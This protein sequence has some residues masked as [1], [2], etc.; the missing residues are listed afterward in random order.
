M[1]YRRDIVYV[2][3]RICYQSVEKAK[4]MGDSLVLI[5][6]KVESRSN[7]VNV[8]SGKITFI[9]DCRYIDVVVLRDFI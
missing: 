7:T 5:F 8:V 2:F 9:I 3:S 1:G 4:R 6:G